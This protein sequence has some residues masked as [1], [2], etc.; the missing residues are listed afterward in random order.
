MFS[1]NS[2]VLFHKKRPV[3]ENKCILLADRLANWLLDWKKNGNM[4]DFADTH[5]KYSVQK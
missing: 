2:S 5:F 1:E 3:P 4:K